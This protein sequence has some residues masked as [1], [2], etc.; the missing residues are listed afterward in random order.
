MK[1]F[2]EYAAAIEPKV[3]AYC[4]K[5]VLAAIAVSLLSCGGAEMQDINRKIAA[6]WWAL[7]HNG[8]VPQKPTM[9][10]PGS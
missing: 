5:A 7:Y 6:E 1:T 9:P 10:E 3:Y 8:I 2:N 4:P